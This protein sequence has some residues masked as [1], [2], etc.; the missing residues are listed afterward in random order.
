[1][2]IYI[3]QE[4]KLLEQSFECLYLEEERTIQHYQD[5]AEA[6]HKLQVSL[7]QLMV[8]LQEKIEGKL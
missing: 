1:M 8:R 5:C 4:I 7:N 3:E 6:T 2:Q